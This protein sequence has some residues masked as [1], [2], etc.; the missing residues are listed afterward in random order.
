MNNEKLLM[1]LQWI[2]DVNFEVVEDGE[3]VPGVTETELDEMI[4]ELKK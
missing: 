3:I 4:Q 2:K 1:C